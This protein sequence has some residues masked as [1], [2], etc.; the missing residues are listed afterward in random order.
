MKKLLLWTIVLMLVVTF[1]LVGCKAAPVA[2]EEEKPVVEEA[3]AVVEEEE[4]VE[5]PSEALTD[6]EKAIEDGKKYAGTTIKVMLSTDASLSLTKPETEE[7]EK[8]TGITVELNEV[9]WDVLMNQIPVA[10]ASGEYAFDVMDVWEDLLN[11]YGPSEGLVNLSDY[12][13]NEF[14]DCAPDA[15]SIAK[16]GD[17]IYAF[18]YLASW[19]IM[20]YNKT[21]FEEAGLD[22][23]VSPKTIDEFKEYIGKLNKDTDGDGVIDQ[24][25]YVADWT[26]EWGYNVFHQYQKAFGGEK[27]E[28]ID[29]KVHMLYDTSESVDA[30]KF[31]ADLYSGGLVDPGILTEAQWEVTTLFNNGEIVFMQMW[32]MYAGFLDEEMLASCGFFPFPGVEDGLAASTAGHEY[33]SIPTSSPNQEAAMAYLKFMCSK[34]NA[35]RRAIKDKASPPYDEL[36]TDPDVKEAMPFLDAV[37]IAKQFAI[38]QNPPIENSQELNVFCI[39]EIHKAIMGEITPEEAMRLVQE[40]ADTGDYPTV[41]EVIDKY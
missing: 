5:E 29:R 6:R 35:K 39:Q 40:E 7:F 9:G 8:L 38:V 10:L 27:F 16:F 36:Y 22:P 11:I 14:A 15:V 12:M 4:V 31:M 19:Q 37:N 20:F 21:L 28:V 26:T 1:S 34:E 24:Y 33:L 41:D 17:S 13:A 18:P 25:A 30:V 23:E 2:V 32:D 3:P